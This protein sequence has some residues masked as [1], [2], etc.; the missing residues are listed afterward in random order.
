VTNQSSNTVSK[1]NSRSDSVEIA[2]FVGTKPTGIA[3]SPDGAYVYVAN[4]DGYLSVI[5]TSD[6]STNQVLV[7]TSLFGVAVAPDGEFIYVTDS[8]ENNLYTIQRGE[9]GLTVNEPLPVGVAPRGVAV[10]QAGTQVVVANS[11]AATVSVINVA[12]DIVTATIEVGNNPFGVAISK[13]DYTAFVTNEGDDSLS[14]ISLLTASVTATIQL[15]AITDPPPLHDGPQGLAVSPYGDSLY[16]VNN[17]SA[18]VKVIT[19]ADNT[20]RDEFFTVGNAPVGLGK[21]FFPETPS[22]LTAT[23]FGDTG[24]D[25][26]WTDNANAETGFTIERRKYSKGFFSEVATVAADVTTY[27][28]RNLDYNANY[29][30]Q[31][32]AAKIDVGST[33]FSNIAYVQTPKE[34]VNNC[35]IATAAFGSYWEP[36]V[37]ILRQFRDSFLLTNPSGRI[38]VK[39]YYKYSPPLA[40]YIA[41]HEAVRAA[42]RNGL[43]PLIG[44]GWLAVNYGIAVPL[45]LAGLLLIFLFILKRLLFAHK[46][47]APVLSQG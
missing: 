17:G 44:F 45:I 5:N 10:N 40:N 3:V 46:E 38:L 11:G 26:H 36:R 7:G 4:Q 15:Y 43:V 22:N 13:D 9:L 30:Y 20:V 12:P 6:N 41:R 24:I 27:S 18:T 32:K 47:K 31:V 35:F 42:V 1:I 28:D 33:P 23:A 16:V 19:L 34:D 14:K 25:L 29:Y 39:T 2:H 21:F 8:S 37:T